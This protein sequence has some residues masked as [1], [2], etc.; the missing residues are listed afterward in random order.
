MDDQT[1]PLLS[2]TDLSA[3]SAAALQ[4]LET[5]TRAALSARREH[6]SRLESEITSQLD[7]VEESLAAQRAADEAGSFQTD[8]ARREIERLQAELEQ[9]HSNWETERS[10]QQAD[11]AALRE[12]LTEREQRQVE[13]AAKL[14]ELKQQLGAKELAL[15]EQAAAIQRQEAELGNRD[16]AFESVRLQRDAD[17]KLFAE[18]E[19]AWKSEQV[20]WDAERKDWDAEK[21]AWDA[22]RS[23]SE[24]SL[25][26][27]KVERDGLVTQL[28]ELE[29]QHQ[30]TQT[31]LQ[32]QLE[33]CEQE[34]RH[35]RSTGEAL[36][37]EWD[38][39]RLALE[40]ER[41]ELKRSL[42]A[43][44]EE[45][46]STDTWKAAAVERDELQQKF[47]LALEDVQ[48]FR[49]R[50]ADLEQELAC[51]P[52]VDQTESAEL[53]ALRA[54]RDALA[55]RVEELDRAPEIP[56]D[57]DAQR[58]LADFQRRF[59]LAVEDVRELK[60]KNAQLEA[61]LAERKPASS[62]AVD[63]TSMDWES[64]KRR[65]LA[66]LDE[67]NEEEIDEPRRKERTTIAA[68]IEMTDA[69]VAEKDLE[70]KDL[71]DQ[72]AANSG[73]EDNTHVASDAA[74]NEIVDADEI[75]QQHRQRLAELEAQMD[76]T[77][78]AAELELS[79][80]RARMARQ[81]VELEELREE[82]AHRESQVGDS[83]VTTG[84]KRRWL[85]KL[86]LSGDDHHG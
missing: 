75:V 50:V 26:S 69:V 52:A 82:L 19:S 61:R 59:E 27:L 20:T 58:Q 68:T 72:L 45:L 18:R 7:A 47:A 29:A 53:V 34:L 16:Q 51:R 42:A 13:Q 67:E 44:Q 76:K 83:P 43:T 2:N 25:S 6:I 36:R 30:S 60:T 28:A 41:D 49:S 57:A 80:E 74:L 77:L 86:G 11:L 70:I 62:A 65:L 38:A 55:D 84:P 35:V 9:A 33:D 17:Q 12:E 46:Q 79:V 4:E 31:S 8:E 81:K 10:D 56:V 48:R 37:T 15:A 63:T 32:S 1:P 40:T 54:E 21:S 66:S 85:S 24:A 14:D 3:R 71:R 39:A 23:L 22:E 5:R 78:R 73:K 64:Q